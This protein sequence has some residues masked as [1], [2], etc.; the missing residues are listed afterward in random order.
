MS[1][2]DDQRALTRHKVLGAV[3]E[4]VAEGSLDELSV[5]A[6]AERSGVSV[7]TIYRYFPTRDELLAAAAA[8][9]SRQ[10]L[11]HP[12]PSRPGDDDLA[13][14][15]R[16]MWHDFAGNLPLLRHQ[17]ASTAGRE[18]RTTRLDR[19]RS[20]L[21][22]Y[23]ERQGID[24]QSDDGQRLISMLLLITGSLGL[25]ELHDRQ[26][27]D[28]EASLDHFALGDASTD[29]GD[30]SPI[31]HVA[32]ERVS[33]H[34]AALPPGTE[35][36]GQPM[37]STATATTFP[38]PGPGGWRRLADHFPRALTPEY[39][40]IYTETCPPGMASYMRRYGVL[41]RTLDVAF[42][43]GHL[44]VTPVPL[45]GSRDQRRAPPRAAVWL[46][47]RMHPEFR[48]RNRAARWALEARPW[49]AV[50]E[51]WFSVERDQW[52]RRNSEMEA[53]DPSEL[54]D[55]QLADH[56]HACR[57]LVVSGYLRHFEL[58]GDDL[59]PV[60]LLIA[61]CQ[62]WGVSPDVATAAL[63]GAS[64]VPDAAEMP[65]WMLVS[66]YDLDCLTWNELGDAPAP[67]VPGAPRVSV[68]VDLRAHVPSEHHHAL[69]EL[70]T[71]ARNAVLLRDD[72]GMVTGA[73]PMGLL[74][75]AMLAAGNRRF[76]TDPT[77]AVEATVDE[78][79]SLLTGAGAL[80]I[81]ELAGR[82]RVRAEH[83]ALDA[84]QAIGPEFAIPPLD[85]LPRP[86]GLIGAAQ[87]ATAEHMLGDE[88]P[89]GI[90]RECYTGRALVV[91]DPTVAMMTFEPGDVI[92]TAAT[93][94]AWNCLLVHAGAL[95]T[96]NGGLVS[97]A[98]VTAREL[99][100]PAIIGEPTAG[101]RLRTGTL[102]T[103]DPVRATV[104]AAQD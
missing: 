20:S 97:H 49:R 5:P 51:H 52:W 74:R 7:A 64:T 103:V 91:D 101:R 24:P 102:V 30:P 100:I 47:S 4:L 16:A 8:E 14:F 19:S 34:V 81:E 87:L 13:A 77:V 79:A 80:T 32:R 67:R 92:I 93:S 96:A 73:W 9:P 78:L 86:M 76:P 57:R 45:A 23:L 75:R 88:H 2:R 83:S 54:D 28:V 58:H 12:P 50:N 27:L 38:A 61:R 22:G 68:P 55:S 3:L 17:M 70:V 95:V 40:L 90:G 41:A 35:Q 94:P 39:Q 59:L 63:A 84:P 71:D 33:K 56:L 66:G 46:M 69:D 53:V 48:R 26:G 1:L 82:R 15:Q 25:I 104:F 31:E 29:P 98:A 11:S 21:A 10:A 99:G 36:R 43:H 65:K 42:V 72:N 44:Y 89:V 60:G 18:M 37:T 85:A 62:E 6:V